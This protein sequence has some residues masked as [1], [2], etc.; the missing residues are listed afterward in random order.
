MPKKK[1]QQDLLSIRARHLKFHLDQRNIFPLM[2]RLVACARARNYDRQFRFFL[3]TRY[4]NLG[5]YAVGALMGSLLFI[6]F[7]PWSVAPTRAGLSPMIGRDSA[8]EPS[9]ES[10]W[11][12]SG[13]L[14]AA[15]TQVTPSR[16]ADYYCATVRAGGAQRDQVFPGRV[17]RVELLQPRL[18]FV[19]EQ[20]AGTGFT[21]SG[22][23]RLPT[24]AR[25]ANFY[26]A[27]LAEKSFPKRAKDPSESTRVCSARL[28]EERT[29]LF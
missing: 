13:S 29:E 18:H 21:M 11:I 16:A 20:S 2:E 17:G 9:I 27:S 12:V 10:D 22:R 26:A 6:I 1:L 24:R 19:A 28:N 7:I 3:T 4:G 8:C 25:V 23:S 14:I 15:S 5:W